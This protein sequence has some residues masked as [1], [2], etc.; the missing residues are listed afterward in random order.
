[1]LKNIYETYLM[2]K[3]AA[4]DLPDLQV[5][6][7]NKM[8]RLTKNLRWGAKLNGKLTYDEGIVDKLKDTDTFEII[9]DDPEVASCLDLTNKVIKNMPNIGTLVTL[10][11]NRDVPHFQPLFKHKGK[12]YIRNGGRYSNPYDSLDE[13]GDRW[14]TDPAIPAPEY[15]DFYDLPADETITE[16]DLRK[17]IDEVKRKAKKTYRKYYTD[18]P[19]YKKKEAKAI[20]FPEEE[21]S[22]LKGKDHFYTTRVSSDYNNY[23]L[24]D[25]VITPWGDAYDI[26]SEDKYNN[27]KDH[28]FY[29]ELTDDQK[30]LL[31]AYKKIKLLGLTKKSSVDISDIVNAYKNQYGFDLSHMKGKHSKKPRYNNGKVANDIPVDAYGGS[32]AK[33]NTIYLNPN[34]D[35]VAKYYGIADAAGLQN[36]IVAHELAHEIYKRQATQEFIKQILAEAKKKKFTTPYLATVPEHK[37]DEETFCEYLANGLNKQASKLYTYVDSNADL[38]QGLLSLRNAP[39]DAVVRR[40]GHQI[41]EPENRTKEKILKWI[42]DLGNDPARPD[43]I[44]ALDA[45]IPDNANEG[46]LRFRNTHKL[47]SWDPEQVKDIKQILRRYN[48]PKTREQVNANFKPLAH[49]NWNKSTPTYKILTESGKIPAELLHYE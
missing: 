43:W 7:R 15:V 49:I 29:D 13:V 42:S 31:A 3:Q 39:E 8:T 20:N 28:K 14:Y 22:N 23:N 16:T 47:V 19:S 2:I 27:L 24:G 48:N 1:M 32:W 37:L 6:P 9:G 12:Y 17:V 46:L 11:S 4:F 45:P 25:T 38:S 21:L 10:Q 26:V 34:M 44:Y 5:N 35:A 18:R 41:K 30:R 33:N 40:Y 36:T